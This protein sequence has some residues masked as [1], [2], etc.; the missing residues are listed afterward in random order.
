MFRRMATSSSTARRLVLHPSLKCFVSRVIDSS[1][2]TKSFEKIHIFDNSF[3]ILS[4]TTHSFLIPP[5]IIVL[6]RLFALRNQTKAKP[7]IEIW[8]Q[9]R[10]NDSIKAFLIESGNAP[11]SITTTF[12]TEQNNVA[13]K[14]VQHINGI[15]LYDLGVDILPLDVDVFTM[16]FSNAF[17]HAWVFKDLTITS[18]VRNSLDIVSQNLG[19]FISITSVG[20]LST[21]IAKTLP[22]AADSNLTHIILIDR[23]SDLITPMISQMNYEGLLAEFIGIDCGTVATIDNKS[24]Q[25]LASFEDPLFGFLCMMNHSEVS[26]EISNRMDRVNGA[27]SKKPDNFSESVEDFRRTAQITIENKTLVDH[28]N[29]AQG[30]FEKMKSDKWFKRAM[31]AEADALDGEI[32]LKDLVND[33]LEYGS[34]L[35][36][37]MKLLCLETLLRGSLPDLQKYIQLICFNHG[38]QQVPYLLR[39]QEAG[40]FG[41]ST[42]KWSNFI[43]PFQLFV[44]KWEELKD[45]AAASYLGYAP[46]SIRVIQKITEGNFNFVSKAMTDDSIKI[47]TWQSGTSKPEGQYIICF[48]GGCTHSEL[49][50]LRRLSKNGKTKFQVLTTNMFS[51]NEF[52]EGLSYGIPGWKSF[53]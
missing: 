36:S 31:N 45:Q 41:T 29:L 1:T 25:I 50:S 34:D 27:L 42:V 46:L 47:E 8:F 38:V 3:E 44:P 12:P 5:D 22:P 51:S 6:K 32:N 39:A 16:N 21:A 15:T 2:L 10:I 52:F 20:S 17:T 37:E 18:I 43:K 13:S 4:D 24:L 30:L 49:N 33:M 53:E 9:P 35:K 23:A 11:Q 14:G 19:G 28:I 7:E 40:I 48:V 26:Y